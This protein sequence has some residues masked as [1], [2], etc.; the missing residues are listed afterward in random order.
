MNTTSRLITVLVAAAGSLGLASGP[1]LAAN[2]HFVSLSATPSGSDLDVSF[3]EAGLGGGSQQTIRAAADYSA[4]FQC[5]N[6][7]GKNP[8]AA[9]KSIETGSAAVSGLFR[10][11]RNG[12]VVGSLKLSAPSISTNDLVCPKGQREQLSQITWTSVG[13]A[14][15]SS[16]ASKSLPV[17]FSSGRVL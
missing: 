7:G 16:G 17:S 8:S 11:D 14:D 5:V 9:N 12:N 6:G 2:P 10:A 3:K 15:L 4:V 1:A 13:V